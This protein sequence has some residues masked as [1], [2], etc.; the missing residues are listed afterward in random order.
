MKS[1]SLVVGLVLCLI[2]SLSYA[3]DVDGDRRIGLPEA[4]N[5]LQI[6]A[7]NVSAPPFV[8]GVNFDITSG[9]ETFTS[10]SKGWTFAGVTPVGLGLSVEFTFITNKGFIFSV[11]SAVSSTFPVFESNDCSGDGYVSSIP[12][13][14]QVF[15]NSGSLFY[16]KSSDTPIDITS[17]SSYIDMCYPLTP[18]L[19]SVLPVYP[20]DPNVTGVDFVDPTNI[21]VVP[22]VAP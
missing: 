15:Q 3:H 2:T 17:Q 12:Q 1:I 6:V 5:A 14:F 11:G 20:N 4:I 18:E 9:S 21:K 22:H 13:R 7:G 19:I 8:T 16:L 10:Y